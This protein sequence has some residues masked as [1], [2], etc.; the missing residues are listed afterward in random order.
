MVYFG[1]ELV[2]FGYVVDAFNPRKFEL[3]L[4]IFDSVSQRKLNIS[5]VRPI[6]VGKGVGGVFLEGEGRRALWTTWGFER[7]RE[8]GV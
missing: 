1:G 6:T 4:R 7:E 3:I 8:S 5:V 2:T